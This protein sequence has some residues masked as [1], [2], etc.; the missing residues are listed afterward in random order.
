M[1]DTFRQHIES[2]GIISKNTRFAVGVSGGVDSIV[3]CDLL[4]KCGYKFA[5]VHCNFSLRGKDSEQDEEF[6]Q[7][8]TKS[9]KLD[10]YSEKFDTKIYSETNGISV[11]MAA[12][13]LRYEYFNRI[14]NENSLDY[15]LTAHHLNDQ[16]ETYFINLTRGSGLNGLKGIPRLSRKI[17]RPLLPFKKSEILYYASMNSISFREDSSNREDKYLRN[18]IRHNIIPK[19][20]ELNPSFEDTMKHEMAL[21]NSYFRFMKSYLKKE[22][23]A[24]L[25]QENSTYL[26]SINKLTK[27]IEPGIILFEILKDF[28]FNSSQ[29]NDIVN[30]LHSISGKQFLSSSHLL[31]KDRDYLII[32]SKDSI[33]LVNE[34]IEISCPGEIDSPVKLSINEVNNLD[35]PQEGNKILID[36]EKINFPLKLKRW[37]LGDS[38]QP[39]G[40]QGTKKLSDFF[41][42]LKLNSFEKHNTWILTDSNES[43]IWVMPYRMDDR[44]KITNKTK[45]GLLIEFK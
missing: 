35:L 19:F 40:M 18:Y 15:I 32:R 13:E 30:S 29:I 14:L 36:Y 7:S 41:I 10:F 24:I 23:D 1:L 11:Q 25:V 2:S 17:Y 16:I 4:L 9:N 42:N 34:I 6:V 31:V 28:N 5:V 39:L 20:I 33:P 45:K 44:Y 8:F 27:S 26:V 22:I 38:F 21:L 12:R 43:I 3:L 37:E